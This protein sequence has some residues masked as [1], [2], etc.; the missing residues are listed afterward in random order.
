MAL[1]ASICPKCGSKGLVPIDDDDMCFCGGNM[2]LFNVTEDEYIKMSDYERNQMIEQMGIKPQISKDDALVIYNATKSTE[3]ID[4]M[5]ELK[6]KDIIEYGLK[7][8]QFKSSLAAQKSSN[9]QT[10]NRPKCPTCGSTNLRKISTTSKVTSVAMWGLFSQK[11][12][13][14]WHCNNCKY[15]W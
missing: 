11:V 12:K 9:T 15:E 8:S 7:L 1:K 10:D 14:T 6:Q 5:I 13:K 2:V 3:I 4:A